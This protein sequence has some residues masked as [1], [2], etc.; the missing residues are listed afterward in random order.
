MLGGE[1]KTDKEYI[2]GREFG[3][4]SGGKKKLYT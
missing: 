2:D 4:V 1:Q 3:F